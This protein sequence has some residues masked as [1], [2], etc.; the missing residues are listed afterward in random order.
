MP[1][2]SGV[3]ARGSGRTLAIATVTAVVGTL[4]YMYV[5]GKQTKKEEG[6]ASIYRDDAPKGVSDARL[7]S[8][9]VRGTVQGDRK[10]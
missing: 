7:N 4:G 9:D 1:A 6:P 10:P 2:N 8:A 3:Q 5:A